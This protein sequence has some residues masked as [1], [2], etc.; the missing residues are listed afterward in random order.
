M[1]NDEVIEYIEIDDDEQ[2]EPEILSNEVEIECELCF[3][4]HHIDNCIHFWNASVEQRKDILASFNLCKICFEKH[5]GTFCEVKPPYCTYPKCYGEHHA[6]VHGDEDDQLIEKQRIWKMQIVDLKR[7]RG[8]G[9]FDLERVSIGRFWN[10]HRRL[11]RVMAWT[12]R[13]IDRCRPNPL[14]GPNPG[15]E[16]ME[17]ELARAQRILYNVND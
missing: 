7:I 14:K 9:V 13:F 12:L 6:L 10:G 5:E 15:D 8:F 3:E 4:K 17:Q 11:R 2:V 16:I 1:E